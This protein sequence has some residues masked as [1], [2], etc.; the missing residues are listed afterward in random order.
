MWRG[1]WRQVLVRSASWAC[2]DDTSSDDD[3]HNTS[4]AFL[5]HIAPVLLSGFT[6]VDERTVALGCRVLF[7]TSLPFL[8][9]IV[10]LPTSTRFLTIL[11]MHL[12]AEPAPLLLSTAF[13]TGGHVWLPL[14]STVCLFSCFGDDSHRHDVRHSHHCE[15]RRDV[16]TAHEVCTV[17]SYLSFQLEN[18][19]N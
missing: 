6:D 1:I 12:G 7:R 13:S 16:E 18:R 15:D 4:N 2:C 5:L 11:G 14:R 19:T 10:L 8:D 17:L 9:K 3:E